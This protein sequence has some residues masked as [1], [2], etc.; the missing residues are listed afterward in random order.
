MKSSAVRK[1]DIEETKRDER[2]VA[3][4]QHSPA[5]RT[6]S[7]EEVI[8]ME[9]GTDD[10]AGNETEH[11]ADPTEGFIDRHGFSPEHE[12]TLTRQEVY[13]CIPK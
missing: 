2:D 4:P 3:E 1:E 13:Q 6:I 9:A 5:K 7:A 10:G 11:D 12:M 8:A